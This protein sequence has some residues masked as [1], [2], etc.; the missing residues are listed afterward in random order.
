MRRKTKIELSSFLVK[1]NCFC[2]FILS[3]ASFELIT[4]FFLH[5]V[6]LQFLHHCL[7]LLD[8]LLL[9]SG[10]DNAVNLRDD[11]RVL[12]LRFSDIV[13]CHNFERKKS[14]MFRFFRNFYV[15]IT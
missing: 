10:F 11:D 12:T 8:C 15:E 5:L 6:A 2:S 14:V 4:C 9:F 13:K 3:I 1:K 7:A